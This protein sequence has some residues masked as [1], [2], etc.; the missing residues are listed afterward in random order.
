MAKRKKKITRTVSAKTTNKE[1]SPV[2]QIGVVFVIVA[3][4]LLLMYAARVSP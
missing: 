1:M 2:M 4:M 3:A